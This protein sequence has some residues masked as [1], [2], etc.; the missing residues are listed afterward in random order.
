MKSSVLYSRLDKMRESLELIPYTKGEN[1]MCAIILDKFG[2]PISI[3]YNSYT[4][5]HPIMRNFAKL[6]DPLP[7]GS[8]GKDKIYIH[9]ELDCINKGYFQ[10]KR[11]HTMIVTRIDCKGNFKLAK[12]CIGCYQIIKDKFENIYYTDNNENL[13]LLKR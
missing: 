8:F 2:I 9:A 12:P 3:G 5:T 11:W 7:D 4:K 1:R 13:V 6:K 10:K